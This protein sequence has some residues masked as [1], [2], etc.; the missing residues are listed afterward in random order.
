MATVGGDTR[1]DLRD[2]FDELWN[3]QGLVVDVKRAVL[4]ALGRIGQE[5]APERIY[6]KTLLELFRE[7]IDA[8]LD[9]D[10]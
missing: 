6:F 1:G 2:W 5:Y 8:R 3:N 9:N 7:E 10:G 4:T